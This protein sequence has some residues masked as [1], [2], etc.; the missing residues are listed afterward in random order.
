MMI[1]PVDAWIVG[2]MYVGYDVY[3]GLNQAA[4][5]TTGIAWQAHLGGAAFAA[6]YFKRGWRLEN[7]TTWKQIFK[8][9]TKL[10]V[11]SPNAD[12]SVA[13]AADE[14]SAEDQLIAR[15][16]KILQQVHQQGESSLT[17]RQR[18]TLERY[19]QLMQQR[20]E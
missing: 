19:S 3:L 6:V 20:R 8:R 13:V 12:R 1:I 10:K 5:G 17:S 15:G 9:Q 4:G 14:L 2:L 11:H 18:K 7:I 16:E